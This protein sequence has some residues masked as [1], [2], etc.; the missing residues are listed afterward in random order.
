MTQIIEVDLLLC[1]GSHCRI[2]ALRENVRFEL[3]LTPGVS[4]GSAAFLIDW[5]CISG[6]CTP[7]SVGRRK[8]AFIRLVEHVS[9][10]LSDVR[11]FV[12]QNVRLQLVGFAIFALLAL[13]CNHVALALVLVGVGLVGI[14]PVGGRSHQVSISSLVRKLG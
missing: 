3:V 10:I 8:D 13:I 2:I 1:H 4:I 6:L 7:V 5:L 9:S 11:I 12:S 14:A